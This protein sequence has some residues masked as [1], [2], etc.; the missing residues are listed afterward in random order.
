MFASGFLGTISITFCLHWS[1]SLPC[2]GILTLF[3]CSQISDT[4]DFHHRCCLS[5]CVVFFKLDLKLI[6]PLFLYSLPHSQNCGVQNQCLRIMSIAS[7][8]EF[9]CAAACQRHQCLDVL[10]PAVTEHVSCAFTGGEM[11]LSLNHP[12]P[13][14][15]FIHCCPQPAKHI[16]GSYS[17]SL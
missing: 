3:G 7:L 12:K 17:Y 2:L 11:N 6:Q 5:R 10:F 8:E 15:T 4:Q 9:S 16:C 13:V 1:F 14:S